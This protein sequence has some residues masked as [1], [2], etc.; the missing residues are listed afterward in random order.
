MAAGKSAALLT[1]A[2][3][4]DAFVAWQLLEKVPH[5]LQGPRLRTSFVVQAA[6]VRQD[7][8]MKD[9]RGVEVTAKGVREEVF[10]L[11]RVEAR[12][13]GGDPDALSEHLNVVC[14]N[15]AIWL[16]KWGRRERA[17]LDGTMGRK[18]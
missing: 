1:R 16:L 11:L 9:S 13:F 15:L 6:S 8:R 18:L 10:P 5:L 2:A 14:R 4:R 12:P 17:F 3:P 7:L